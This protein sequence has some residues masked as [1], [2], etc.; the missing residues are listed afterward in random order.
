RVDRARPE[1][2]EEAPHAGDALITEVAALLVWTQEHEVRAERICA[3][4]FDVFVRV[5]DVAATLRHLRAFANDH[6]M[7][8]KLREW[9]LEIEV[10]RIVEH[11]RHEPRIEQMQHR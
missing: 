2:I 1:P 5:H 9:L 8:A 4:A 10:T 7:R 6:P 11:H 3:P